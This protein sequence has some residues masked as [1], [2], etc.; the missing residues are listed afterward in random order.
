[1]GFFVY[2]PGFMSVGKVPEYSTEV[3]GIYLG[4]Y[5]WWEGPSV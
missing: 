2:I 4:F 5:V 1:M 3:I